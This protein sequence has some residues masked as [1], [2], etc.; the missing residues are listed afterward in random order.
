MTDE[1]WASIRPEAVIHAK[2]DD[3]FFQRWASSAWP[4]VCSANI[5]LLNLQK[6]RNTFYAP[7]TDH[8]HFLKC[9]NVFENHKLKPKLRTMNGT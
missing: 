5:H 9:L 3:I 7:E 6:G 4:K 2:E 1:N 8:L